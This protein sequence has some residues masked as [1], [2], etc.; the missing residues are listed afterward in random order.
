M[1]GQETVRADTQRRRGPVLPS[2][3]RFC[4]PTRP[5]PESY[6]GGRKF[7]CYAPRLCHDSA[8]MARQRERSRKR[9]RPREKHPE[10]PRKG[11][12]EKE[13]EKGGGEKRNERKETM[14]DAE[15]EA[16]VRPKVLRTVATQQA[17]SLGSTLHT[18]HLRS[19]SKQSSEARREAPR[20]QMRKAVLREVQ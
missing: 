3:W 1:Y 11:K 14:E 16:Q 18:H 19:S 20:V 8:R 17:I 4:L 6:K 5:T 13:V 7:S 15:R 2:A 12:A 10:R 9:P